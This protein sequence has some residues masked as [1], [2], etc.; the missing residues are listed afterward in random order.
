MEMVLRSQVV[1]TR[2]NL[3]VS[4]VGAEEHRITE[5]SIDQRLEPDGRLS[6]LGALELVVYSFEILSQCEVNLSLIILI[7]NKL[8][9]I[10]VS[11]QNFIR[12]RGRCRCKGHKNLIGISS[13]LLPF[14][15]QKTLGFTVV[16][17]VFSK[18]LITGRGHSL[19]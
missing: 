12:L 14:A 5:R 9:A 18:L 6:A 19:S 1:L 7:I 15:R 13:R 10:E 17:A 16:P 8:Q 11:G 4:Q 2:H 3:N